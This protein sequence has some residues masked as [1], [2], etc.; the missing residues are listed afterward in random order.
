[1]PEN[2]VSHGREEMA[3][4]REV[5]RQEYCSRAMLL[6][7]NVVLSWQIPDHAAQHARLKA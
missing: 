5:D 3:G 6:V 1:M 4:G 7:C 2:H